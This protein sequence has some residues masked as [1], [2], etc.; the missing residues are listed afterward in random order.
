MIIDCNEWFNGPRFLRK[1]G[2]NWP[3]SSIEEELDDNDTELKSHIK[4]YLVS[5]A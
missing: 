2:D 5:I 1:L 3:S 4:T